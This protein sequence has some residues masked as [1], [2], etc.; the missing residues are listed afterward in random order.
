MENKLTDNDLRAII[1][2]LIAKMGQK[3]AAD[4]VALG[5]YPK[6]LRDKAMDMIN[7]KRELDVEFSENGVISDMGG[8]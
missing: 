1:N 3:G 7:G 8:R 4:Y 5:D 6:E 2:K